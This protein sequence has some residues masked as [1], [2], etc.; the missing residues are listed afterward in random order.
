[1]CMD[2]ASVR[3]AGEKYATQGSSCSEFITSEDI[4]FVPLLKT[5]ESDFIGCNRDQRAELFAESHSENNSRLTLLI[6]T[7]RISVW[8]SVG[9][10]VLV[11]SYI[12]RSS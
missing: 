3:S 11:K 4:N 2:S 5:I 9:R 1:M 6:D 7:T 8:G 12:Q 10:I